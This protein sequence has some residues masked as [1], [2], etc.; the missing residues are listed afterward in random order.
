MRSEALASVNNR[1]QP[2]YMPLERRLST[3]LFG[4]QPPRTCHL[5]LLV[6]VNS[7]RRAPARAAVA[8]PRMGNFLPVRSIDDRQNPFFSCNQRREARRRALLRNK[9]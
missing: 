9:V 4:N 1:R 7:V 5:R 2:S 6:T 8:E 3:T